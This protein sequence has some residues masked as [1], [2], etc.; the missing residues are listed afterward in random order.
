MTTTS[1]NKAPLRTFKISFAYAPMERVNEMMRRFD[2][3]WGPEDGVC[4]EGTI[5]SRTTLP[6]DEYRALIEKAWQKMDG[7]LYDLYEVVR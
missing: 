7:K 2:V 3:G 5:T 6:I 4:Q 1:K